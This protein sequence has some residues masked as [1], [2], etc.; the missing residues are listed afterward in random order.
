MYGS[1]RPWRPQHTCGSCGVTFDTH[2]DW[3]NHL[4]LS[5]I[6]RLILRNQERSEALLAPFQQFAAALVEMST[7]VVETALPA[8]EQ[9]A[10][11]A[12]E[13]TDVWAESMRRAFNGLGE[14]ESAEHR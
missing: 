5:E 12:G 7:V 10:R 4:C 8:F 11:A 2:Y 1:S 14:S 13:L 9:L 6:Q 3:R